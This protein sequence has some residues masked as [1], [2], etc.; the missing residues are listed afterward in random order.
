MRT[1]AARWTPDA[2]PVGWTSWLVAPC[3]VLL[4]YVSDRARRSP[5]H[6]VAG[7]ALRITNTSR[8]VSTY[9]VRGYEGLA[10]RVMAQMT[11]RRIPTRDMFRTPQ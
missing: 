5:E 1:A 3:C 7:T 6:T 4:P 9:I 10:I 11:M 8:R 2:V